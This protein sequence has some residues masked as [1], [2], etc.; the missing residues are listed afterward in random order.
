M[1][2]ISITS[3]LKQKL[4]YHALQW[5]KEVMSTLSQIRGKEMQARLTP[6]DRYRLLT[7]KVWTLRYQISLTFVLEVLQ[8]C[9]QNCIRGIATKA[10]LGIRVTTLCSR[11]SQEMLEVEILKQFPHH[12]NEQL[13][14][15]QK[16]KQMTPRSQSPPPDDLMTYD[17]AYQT[18]LDN[19]RRKQNKTALILSRRPWRGNPWR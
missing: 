8:Q 18:W 3:P 15:A 5:E 17:T 9:Y 12:E 16:Q 1:T 10:Y 7:L 2:E 11:R 14:K 19:Q 6:Y 13:W 4:D